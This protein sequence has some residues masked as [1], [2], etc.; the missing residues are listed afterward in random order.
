MLQRPP[1]RT[2]PG[3][4][5][6]LRPHLRGVEGA[7]AAQGGAAQRARHGGGPCAE[8]ADLPVHIRSRCIQ[9]LCALELHPR[10]Y[11]IWGLSWFWLRA[12]SGL[13]RLRAPVFSLYFH[14]FLIWLTEINPQ[15]GPRGSYSGVTYL[16]GLLLYCY[17]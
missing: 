5:P 8:G 11:F 16:R 17:T 9:I 15:G 7:A 2:R 3:H 14:G 10:G 12:P 4:G 1:R 6:K 13:F